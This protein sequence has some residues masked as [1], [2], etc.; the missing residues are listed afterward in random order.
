MNQLL[1][2]TRNVHKIAE[3]RS[4]LGDIEADLVTLDDF[5]HVQE[6]KEDGETLEE[7]ALKKAR[8]ACRQTRLPA[9]AD[10]SGLE[11]YYLNNEP[12][13]YSSRYAGPDA[14]YSDNYRKLLAKL[15]GVPQRRRSARF[16]CVLAFVSPDGIEKIAEGI[17][18]GVITEQ[19]R[20]THGFGYDP[21]FVPEGHETT[22]AEMESKLKN[23]LSHRAKA[24]EIMRDELRVIFSFR[25]NPHGTVLRFED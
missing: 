12:G 21:V 6:T 24:F 22:F 9:L 7:N 8:E 16:R 23:T 11:V 13:V 5:P 2:A 20:G 18:R 14:T 19:P 25:G 1:L 17:C 4:F 3:M 10:D 15:R